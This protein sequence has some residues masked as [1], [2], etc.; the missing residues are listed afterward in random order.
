MRI[1]YYIV[2]IFAFGLL[3]GCNKQQEQTT[4]V[5]S[6]TRI[7]P[8]KTIAAEKNHFAFKGLYIGMPKEAALGE[9][10]S[11][12][13]K[14]MHEAIAINNKDCNIISA[15]TEPDENGNV[16]NGWLVLYINIKY[17]SVSRIDMDL[18]MVNHIFNASDLSFHDFAGKFQE[19]YGLPEMKHIVETAGYEAWR[20]IDYAEGFQLDIWRDSNQMN[21]GKQ[22]EIIQVPKESEMRFD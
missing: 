20:Y 19:N 7:Q 14:N 1:Y 6:S 10:A 22:I 3:L 11:L 13:L 5:P 8:P 9:L 12:G 4:S 16:R 2:I 21:N 18:W 15:S 17:N